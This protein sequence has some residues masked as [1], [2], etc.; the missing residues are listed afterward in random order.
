MAIKHAVTN[1]NFSNESTWNGD[2][3]I[4]TPMRKKC[5]KGY[6]NESGNCCCNCKHQ[7]KVMCH[8][9]NGN[10]G[11]GSINKQMGWVCMAEFED[12]SNK[13]EYMFFDFEHGFCELYMSR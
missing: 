6:N 3:L 11:K 9:K 7:K 1:G 10:I 12:R 8:P 2:S 5:D 13:D 4:S